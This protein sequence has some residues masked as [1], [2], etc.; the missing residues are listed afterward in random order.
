MWLEKEEESDSDR[1]ITKI[2]RG[3]VLH[4]IEVI[5]PLPLK[6]H[7]L[8]C[9]YLLGGTPI[10]ATGTVFW[11]QVPGQHSHTAQVPFLGLPRSI[12]AGKL[13]Q[14]HSPHKTCS[15]PVLRASSSAETAT[16]GRSPG[17]TIVRLYRIPTRIDINKAGLQR[18]KY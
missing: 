2:G 15:K 18:L 16:E 6:L 8:L 17:N 14:S 7:L 11:T 1:G 5:L 3:Q 9:K 4:V 13:C 12:W 10:Q